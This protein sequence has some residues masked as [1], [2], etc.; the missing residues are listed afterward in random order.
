MELIHTTEPEILFT[1]PTEIQTIASLAPEI[2]I[3][4][5]PFRFNVYRRGEYCRT[6]N[7]SPRRDF[8]KISLMIGEGKLHFPD[9]SVVIDRNALIVYNPAL[10][11]SFEHVSAV[12][13]GYF[14]LFNEH[15]IKENAEYDGIAESPL[16]KLGGSP[17]YFLNN[18]QT[19]FINSIFVKMTEEM[20]TNYE[21]K[22]AILRSCVNLILH[23]ALKIPQAETSIKYLNASS[24]IAAMF[25][26]LLE[27]QFPV[28]STEHSLKLKTPNDFAQRLSVHVNHLNR[29]IKDTTGKNTSQLIADRV[30]TEAKALLKHTD[31]NISEI[32][33]SLGFEHPSNFNIF[34][35]KQ[36]GLTPKDFR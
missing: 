24:R 18:A 12:Q 14:C 25:N 5:N 4:S 20:E 15:F 19:A 28:D 9:H 26:A 29:A 2:P 31:S 3:S 7:P 33:Y 6:V 10:P 1:E 16:L 27:R 36:T 11:Y 13:S 32:A 35:R 17:V 30:A 8:Y 34:F 21:H 22:Y 23:E